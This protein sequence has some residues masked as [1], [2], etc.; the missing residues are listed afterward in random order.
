MKTE[1]L[2]MYGALAVAAYFVYE[3]FLKGKIGTGSTSSDTST[4]F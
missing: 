2:L 1:K 4:I 3:K